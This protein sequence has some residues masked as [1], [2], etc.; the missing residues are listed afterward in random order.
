METPD[1]DIPAD[2]L[3]AT[4]YDGTANPEIVRAKLR[5]METPYFVA[6]FDPDEAEMAGAFI[7]DALSDEDALES[8]VDRPDSVEMTDWQKPA[9]PKTANDAQFHPS[10]LVF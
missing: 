8:A 4:P 10:V 3:A 1:I 7:E 5:D 9:P 6:E 2:M